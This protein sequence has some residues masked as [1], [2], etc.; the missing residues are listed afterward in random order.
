MDTAMVLT[1]PLVLDGLNPRDL[2][3]RLNIE[4]PRTANP[5]RLKR[6]ALKATLTA[7]PKRIAQL[8]ELAAT[9]DDSKITGQLEVADLAKNALRFDVSLDTLDVD[10]CFAAGCNGDAGASAVHRR[11]IRPP[12]RPRPGAAHSTPR[13]VSGRNTQSEADCRPAR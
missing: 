8:T 10:S 12:R 7:T 13:A 9:L 11:M 3:A 1:G 2:L 5:E 6:A 4:A